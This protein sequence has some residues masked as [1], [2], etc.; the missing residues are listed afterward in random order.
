MSAGPIAQDRRGHVVPAASTNA[1]ARVCA[2][3]DTQGRGYCGRKATGSKVTTDWAAVVCA[4]C[5]A[6]RR[7]DVA[8][9]RERTASGLNARRI[10]P[11]GSTR[12][13]DRCHITDGCGGD[14]ACAYLC[15]RTTLGSPDSER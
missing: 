15:P 11:A 2:A 10:Q 12:G 13:Y 9:Q 4:D 8:A 7:A 3:G 1:T 5:M 14:E 6:A